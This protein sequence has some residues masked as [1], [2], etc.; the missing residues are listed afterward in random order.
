[1]A[2]RWVAAFSKGESAM[3][4]CLSDHLAP[5]ALA[6]RGLDARMESYRGLREKLGEL[7]LVK[8]GTS[9]PTE[10][11]A[12]LATSE[13]TEREFTFEVQPRPPHKLVRVAFRDPR[14]AGHGGRF[15]H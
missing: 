4:A 12:T 5:E 11:V 9:K 8:I 10:V 1:M 2:R 7:M 13:L 14:A 3:R 15:S 6:K